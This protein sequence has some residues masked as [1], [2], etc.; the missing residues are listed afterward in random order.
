[1]TKIGL[2]MTDPKLRITDYNDI[3]LLQEAILKMINKSN[4][5][6]LEAIGLL[7]MI[8]LSIYETM[9]EKNYG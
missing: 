7:E 1:M 8:K 6:N 2:K 9:M 4:I 3:G 5:S